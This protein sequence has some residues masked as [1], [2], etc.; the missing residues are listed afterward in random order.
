MFDTSSRCDYEKRNENSRMIRNE[1]FFSLRRFVSFTPVEVSRNCTSA[2]LEAALLTMFDLVLFWFHDLRLGFTIVYRGVVH[3]W[4]IWRWFET[5]EETDTVVVLFSFASFDHSSTPRS[6]V[7]FDNSVCPSWVGWLLCTY[8][9]YLSSPT[10][11]MT[12]FHLFVRVS[13]VTQYTRGRQCW[14]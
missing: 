3:K 12:L 4:V 14:R 2:G 5:D 9:W 11:I 7:C 10:R 1:D 8:Y 13:C 6:F